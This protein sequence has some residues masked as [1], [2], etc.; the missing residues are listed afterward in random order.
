MRE[1]LQQVWS[2]LLYAHHSCFQINFESEYIKSEIFICLQMRLK[3][4]L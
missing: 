1:L 3:M 2:G 4:E